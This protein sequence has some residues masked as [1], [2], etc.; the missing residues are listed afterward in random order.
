MNINGKS[1]LVTGGAGFIGSHLIDKLIKKNVKKLVV[2]DNLFYGFERNLEDARIK[3]P[4][5]KFYKEDI[6]D[7]EKMKEIFEKE[8]PEIVFN[9]A[10]IPLPASFNKPMWIFEHNIKMVEVICELQRLGLFKTLIHFSSSEACGSAHE[11]KAMSETHPL[12]PTTPYGASK[13]ASDLLVQSYGRCFK[14]DYSIIRPFNNYGPRQKEPGEKSG[15][16]YGAVIPITIRKIIGNQKPVIHGD[17]SQTRDFIYVED[18]ADAAIK[19]YEN[20]NTRNKIINIANGEETKIIDLIQTII[21]E[22]GWN[23]GFDFDETRQSDI[24][25]HWANINLAK[26]LINFQPKTSLEEGIKKTVEWYKKN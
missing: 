3:F 22:M 17:G 26:E 25:S 19:I 9:L 8:N 16:G 14:T 11:N 15:V 21:K 6:T 1:I 12:N 20:E 13:A 10:V 4:E 5:L 2:V 18:T 24:K 23:E 7:F